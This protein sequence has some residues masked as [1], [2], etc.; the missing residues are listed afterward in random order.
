[1]EKYSRQPRYTNTSRINAP[2]VSARPSCAGAERGQ[3]VERRVRRMEQRLLEP[4]HYPGHRVREVDVP[5]HVRE[6][7]LR[8]RQVRVDLADRVHD[9]REP[10]PD[11]QGEPDQVLHVAV[12]N[13]ERRDEHRQR[14]GEQQQVDEREAD[15][16]TPC[17]AGTRIRRR[18]GTGRTPPT[19]ARSRRGRPRPWRAAGSPGGSRPSSRG[20]RSRSPIARRSGRIRRTGSTRADPASRN[21]G[22][23]TTAPPSTFATKLKTIEEHH[24][25]EERPHGAEHRGRVLDLELLA[26]EVPQDLAVASELAQADADAQARRLGRALGDVGHSGDRETPCEGRGAANALLR[27]SLARRI[28][29]PR[30]AS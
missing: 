30:Q 29:A 3:G 6:R 11:E 22:Y 21:G 2:I 20:S 27:A 18:S 10:E 12:A 23:G 8:R 16:S 14:D 1:M 24:R 28:P 17:R 25:V 7:V 9:R 26:D 5:R 19:A 13:V 15:R 4:V